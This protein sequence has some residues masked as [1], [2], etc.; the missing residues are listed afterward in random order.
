MAG[1]TLPS[2][3]APSKKYQKRGTSQE[4]AHVEAGN[5]PR[6]EDAAHLWEILDEMQGGVS[7][8]RKRGK[9]SVGLGWAGAAASATCC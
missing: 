5:Q 2:R 8:F 7:E 1:W 3:K 6:F 9:S 4:S